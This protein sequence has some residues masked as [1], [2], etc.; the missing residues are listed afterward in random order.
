MGDKQGV[1]SQG[2]ILSRATKTKFSLERFIGPNPLNPS[3]SVYQ[4]WRSL[5]RAIGQVR[6]ISVA[7]YPGQRLTV[8]NVRSAPEPTH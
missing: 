2:A 5:S 6:T 4:V 8:R 3:H 7:T 1:T